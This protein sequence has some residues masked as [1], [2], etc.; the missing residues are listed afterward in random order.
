MLKF[1]SYTV[2]AVPG[3]PGEFVT[4]FSDGSFSRWVPA[5][6]RA[7]LQALGVLA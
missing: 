6:A 7:E 3:E 4:T 1:D 5:E 2:E